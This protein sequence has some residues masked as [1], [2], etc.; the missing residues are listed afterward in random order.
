[1]AGP[2]SNTNISFENRKK[3]LYTFATLSIY[4]YAEM[5]I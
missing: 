3:K 1:M 4:D 2:I 5:D